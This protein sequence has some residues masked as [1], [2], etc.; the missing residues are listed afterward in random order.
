VVDR[1]VVT[2]VEGV[3]EEELLVEEEE[4]LEE[5]FEELAVTMISAQVE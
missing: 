4:L 5:V 1:P 3:E 2:G